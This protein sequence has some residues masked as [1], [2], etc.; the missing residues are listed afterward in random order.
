MLLQ[1]LSAPPLSD[2]ESICSY[3][4]QIGYPEEIK[5][6][7]ASFLAVELAGRLSNCRNIFVCSEISR[8]MNGTSLPASVIQTASGI[9]A[10]KACCSLFNGNRP[11][12]AS[13]L[14]DLC[15]PDWQHPALS[16]IFS[17]SV[18]NACTHAIA[19]SQML[20]ASTLSPASPAQELEEVPISPMASVS[21]CLAA[22]F[23][24]S[25]H[26]AG[27]KE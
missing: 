14:G 21:T 23:R 11:M 6:T 19:S 24:Y 4:A 13:R 3:A 2:K 9:A 16:F 20:A 12:Q 7:D 22:G 18:L 8:W 1:S 5:K 26:S 15:I 10:R 27:I 17:R 25:A